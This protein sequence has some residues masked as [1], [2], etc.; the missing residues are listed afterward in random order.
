MMNEF[1]KK[2]QGIKLDNLREAAM[3]YVSDDMLRQLEKLLAGM[4][5]FYGY[6][7]LQLVYD[8]LTQHYGFTVSEEAF[9][10]VCDYERHR[11]LDH[12]FIIG[13]EENFEDPYAAPSAPMERL[14]VHEPYVMF[15]DCYLLLQEMKCGKPWYIPSKEFLLAKNDSNSFQDANAEQMQA[16]KQWLR[17]Q[18]HISGNMA[19]DIISDMLLAICNEDSDIDDA[20]DEIQRRDIDLTIERIT[21]FIPYFIEL[22]NHTRTAFNNGYTPA[23]AEALRA[24]YGF[25]SDTHFLTSITLDEEREAERSATARERKDVLDDMV[26]TF[27]RFAALP[28]FPATELPRPQKKISKNAPCPCGSGKKYKRCCG[29]GM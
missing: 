25:T 15:E 18:C 12:F 10:A 28:E 16:A 19:D 5:E 17:K 8:T 21:Q 2:Y 7:P 6:M 26:S 29:K 1:P 27:R 24:E 13:E 22:N 20:L 23:E 14:L 4:A 11:Q 9:L 3:K